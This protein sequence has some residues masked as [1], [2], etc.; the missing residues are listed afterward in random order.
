[1]ITN[2]SYMHIVPLWFRL[3]LMYPVHLI[4]VVSPWWP[5]VEL[6]RIIRTEL[7]LKEI[8]R[9][10]AW[11]LVHCV[12][13]YTIYLQNK[14]QTSRSW[15]RPLLAGLLD[16]M[17]ELPSR[18]IC[19]GHLLSSYGISKLSYGILRNPTTVFPVL[20]LQYRSTGNCVNMLLLLAASCVL[21]HASF[22]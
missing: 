19:V 8:L 4:S 20:A 22:K 1:M 16:C 11:L 2:G 7:R 6:R 9:L 18:V 3:R 5:V 21:T 12:K 13:N 15:S 14:D 10:Q 17:N